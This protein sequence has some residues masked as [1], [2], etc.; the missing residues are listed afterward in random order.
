M[1]KK[2]NFTNLIVLV[3]LSILNSITLAGVELNTELAPEASTIDTQYGY[4]DMFYLEKDF[5]D[6]SPA[7][8]NDSLVVGEL[9]IDGGD[10]K[11]IMN[12]A[13]EIVDN[14]EGKFDSILISHQNKLI[15]ESYYRRGR[16]DLPHMQASVTK[17]YLTLA[18][19]RAIQLGHLTMNDLHKPIVNFL[20]DLDSDKFVNGVENITL[21]KAMTMQSG[22]RISDERFAI[23]RE[24]SR[25]IRGFNHTQEFLQHSEVI[26]SKSQ[27]FKYDAVGPKLTMHVLDSIVPGSAKDFIK[28]EVLTK[29]GIKN[30]D[31]MNEING[32]PK[33]EQGSSFT[34]RD[35]IKFG[36]LVMNKGQWRNEQLISEAYIN[37]AT[38]GK[39]QPTEDWIPDNYLYGYFWYQTEM[40]VGDNNYTVNFAW[41]AG[42]QYILTVEKLELVITFTSNIRENATMQLVKERIL[43][44][45]VNLK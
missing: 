21:H 24:E 23:I 33:S 9:G 19:G 42:E 27:T 37:Q 34:S 45:F 30:Y 18:I 2:Y 25:K 35:M 5:I 43:P 41:G 38:N 40:K 44:A 8:R 13:Q 16:V 10:K 36:Q 3:L 11:M 14:N 15:F 4:W 31:W 1:N 29:I 32:L 7:D 20:K 6:S 39:T 26:L 28:N 17:A 22:V 12:L